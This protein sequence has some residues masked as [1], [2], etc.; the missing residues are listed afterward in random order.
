MKKLALALALSTSFIVPAVAQN[1]EVPPAVMEQ[2]V[3]SEK[4]IAA[5]KARKDPLLILAAI[6]IRSSVDEALPA[7]PDTLT[8]REEALAAAR[9]AAAGQ[10]DVLELIKDVESSGSRR[11]CI[12]ARNGVCF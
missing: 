8:S 3:I 4:L 10:D 12:Y 5:G 1:A 2:I 7:A 6:R 9:E 11:M